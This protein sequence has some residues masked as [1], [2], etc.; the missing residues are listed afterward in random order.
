MSLKKKN[1][2]ILFLNLYYPLHIHNVY[3]IW[4]CKFLL[5]M[6]LI[7]NILNSMSIFY[8]TL[9]FFNVNKKDIYSSAVALKFLVFS[10]L[11]CYGFCLCTRQVR[12]ILSLNLND[13]NSISIEVLVSISLKVE[14]KHYLLHDKNTV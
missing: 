4:S 10:N 2:L 1:N 7:I 6:E 3:G 8:P 12:C 14:S 11:S 13:S 5:H 9:T